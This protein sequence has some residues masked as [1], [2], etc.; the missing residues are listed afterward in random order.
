MNYSSLL[1]FEVLAIGLG[2]ARLRTVV[3]ANH[4][5]MHGTAHGGFLFSLADEAFGLA[6]N[7][8][9]ATAVALNVHMDY[10]SVVREG[11]VLEAVASEVHLGRRVATYHIEVRRG[12]AVVAVLSGTV[13]RME[14]GV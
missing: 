13:Y 3:K 4:L 12:E 7:S 2:T 8:H 10:F 5:N 1:G 9:E 14:K 6:A 11:D